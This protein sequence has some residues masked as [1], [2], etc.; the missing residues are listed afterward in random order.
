MH[1]WFVHPIVALALTLCV[2]AYASGQEPVAAFRL[3]S[4]LSSAQEV[5]P[6]MNPTLMGGEV[7][8]EL[9]AGLSEVQATL[10]LEGDAST[11]IGAHLHC[12]R[13][14]VDGPIFFGLVNPGM[15]DAAQLA[16]GMLTCTLTNADIVADADCMGTVERPI[17]NIAALFFAAR[18]GLVYFN[19][20]TMANP[21][22]ELRGQ[23]IEA[24]RTI[25]SET[26]L[27]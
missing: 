18:E 15:C 16:A 10:T 3:E 11:V 5:T 1:K 9:D 13:P 26:S 25:L 4:T 27:P 14:G 24:D 17:S 20:H 22:G 12:A 6:P 2:V 23:L 21:A 7:T 8:I 19:V